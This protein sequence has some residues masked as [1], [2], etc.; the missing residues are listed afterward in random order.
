MLM[1]I[2]TAEGAELLTLLSK[3]S[4]HL[5]LDLCSVYLPHVVNYFFELVN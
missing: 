4:I 1:R 5:L 3:S 2:K